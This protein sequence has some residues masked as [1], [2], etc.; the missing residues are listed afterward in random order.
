MRIPILMSLVI[1]GAIALKV[2]TVGAIVMGL[3]VLGPIVAAFAILG[4][5]I[6]AMVAACVLTIRFLLFCLRGFRTAT[7]PIPM[8]LPVEP[9]PQAPKPAAGPGKLPW[10]RPRYRS[11]FWSAFA[12]AVV[13]II[14]LCI[15]FDSGHRHAR[16]F[17]VNVQRL[18]DS[19]ARIP[20]RVE[21]ELAKAKVKIEQG[22][23]I[24]KD[25][26]KQYADK[27]RKLHEA[28]MRHV[29]PPMPPAP[30][31]SDEI[32]AEV[33]GAMAMAGA[34]A[35]ATPKPPEAVPLASW[36]IPTKFGETKEKA[37]EKALKDA[38]NHL[39]VFLREQSPPIAW[40]P[41]LEYVR[42]WL[43]KEVTPREKEVGTD[44]VPGVDVV[45]QLN[46]DQLA[47]IRKLDQ[48]ER[49]E[50][51]LA[52]LAKLLAGFVAGLMALSGYIRLDEWSKG[53][54]T[55]WL[56]IA[57]VAFIGAVG[58]GLWFLRV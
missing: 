17:N 9:A 50:G 23:R 38:Q 55:G 4:V 11:S 27:M 12:V 25:R 51:R 7:P 14:L 54:Y 28:Q 19:I 46:S 16:H 33:E 29:R 31:D 57:A 30:P 36:T 53:Y 22:T 5:T 13:I 35:R 56:R 2:V 44:K 47:A 43:V 10:E 45:V 26:E 52:T 39:I 34:E 32:D 21:A 48:N 58:A 1:V 8:V 3:A 41:P 40:K 20:A 6:F 15:G 18:E 49:L 42:D 24:I 37:L